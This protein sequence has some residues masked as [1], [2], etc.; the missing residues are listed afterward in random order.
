MPDDNNL[1]IYGET[2]RKE[3][4]ILYFS[5][6]IDFA[7]RNG[8]DILEMYEFTDHA[9]L[10]ERINKYYVKVPEKHPFKFFQ[11]VGNSQIPVVEIIAENLSYNMTGEL[12][13]GE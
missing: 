7:L 13:L 11:M 9:C 4:V 12:F 3:K 5:N 8:L 10:N 1:V 2:H 6:V